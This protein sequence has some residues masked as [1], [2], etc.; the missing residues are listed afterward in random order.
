MIFAGTEHSDLAK[1]TETTDAYVYVDFGKPLTV[2]GGASPDAGWVVSVNLDTMQRTRMFRIYGGSTTS[3]H[4]S[5]KGYD[6][7]GWVVVSSYNCSQAGGYA[8]DK[9]FAAEMQPNGEILNL[10]H[11]YLCEESGVAAEDRFQY[12]TEPHAVVSRDFSHVYFNSNSNN[13]DRIAE[14]YRID[15]P[16][17]N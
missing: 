14:V 8:C 17:F 5:G 16:N 6:R 15:V 2:D 3:L 1:L 11:T 4:I 10:A 13:C 12:F 9:V 7:P